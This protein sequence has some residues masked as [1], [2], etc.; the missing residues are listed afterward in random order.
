MKIFKTT[1]EERALQKRQQWVASHP[2]GTLFIR[3]TKQSGSLYVGILLGYR[4][5]GDDPIDAELVVL[6]PHELL[7][8]DFDKFGVMFQDLELFKCLNETFVFTA[9]ARSR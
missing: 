5:V 8:V 7:V 9:F 3:T 1:Y 2:P 4:F 6:T